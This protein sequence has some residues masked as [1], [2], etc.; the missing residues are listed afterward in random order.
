MFDFVRF[1]PPPMDLGFSGFVVLSE[2]PPE[3]K[4]GG[5]IVRAKN[6]KELRERLK[7][8]KNAKVAVECCSEL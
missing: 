6:P 7:N 2:N 5:Y 4:Y 8:I 3:E 1:S